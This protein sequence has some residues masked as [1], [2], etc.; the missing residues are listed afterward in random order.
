MAERRALSDGGEMQSYYER[1]DEA[2][3]LA[4]GDGLLEFAR[5]K[6]LIQ[7]FLASPPGV[8]LDVGGGPGRYSCWL[9]RNGYE[10]HLVDPVEKH[11]KQA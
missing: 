3:R 1:Y 5:M 8:V 6:E 11:V 4:R 2:G 10:V 9:A 7:R